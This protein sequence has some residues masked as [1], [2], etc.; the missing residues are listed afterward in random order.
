MSRRLAVALTLASAVA[1]CQA[2]PSDEGGPSDEA[3]MAIVYLKDQNFPQAPGFSFENVSWVTLT[4]DATELYMLQRGSPAVSVWSL[5]GQLLRSWDTDML[6]DP[7]SLRFQVLENGAWRIW[8]TDMAGPQPAGSGWGH[9]VKAFDLAGGYLG[10]AGVC[11]ENSAGSGLDPI[12]FDEVTDVGFSPEGGFFATDGDINGLNNRVVQLNSELTA[13]TQ[14]WTGPG[15]QPGAAP[16]EFNLPHAIDIDACGRVYVAD[17]LNHRIQ[18][19]DTEGAVLQELPCFGE[20]GVYGVRARVDAAGQ[21]TLYVSASPPQNAEGGTVS[22][23]PLAGCGA[24]LPAPNQC[25]P[26]LSWDIAL[27]QGSSARLLHT[28]D[29]TPDGS[30]LYFAPLGGDLPPE[31]WVRLPVEDRR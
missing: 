9:C 28:V 8:I 4:P 26:A 5:D 16:G 20:L 2:P 7:H 23:F 18:I 6:G 29:A 24:P 13:A 17:A 22:L 14:V 11:A 1:A 3:E 10:S 12:Q 31:R 21:G 15:G 27:P 30:A 25:A 19:F